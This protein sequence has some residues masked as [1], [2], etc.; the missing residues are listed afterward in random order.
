MMEENKDKESRKENL[1]S[2]I[3][4]LHEGQDI[5]ELKLRFKEIIGGVS[6]SEIGEIEQELI[7]EGILS[8]EE[9]TELCDL[10]VEIFKESLDEKQKPESIPGHPIHT[11]MLENTKAI[12]LIHEIRNTP[13][14]DQLKRIEELSKIDV[15]YTRMENQLFPLLENI[16]ISG[17]P[18]V[19]WAVHDDIRDRFRKVDLSMIKKLLKKVEDLIYKEENILFPMTL[20]KFTEKDWLR[21]REGEEE[22]GYAW[23]APGNEWKPI[24]TFHI[25]S[26]GDISNHSEYLNLDTGKLTLKQVNLMLKYLPVDISFVD[27]NNEVKYYSATDDRIF[28]RSPAVIGRKV[29]KC[30]PPKSVH[31]VEDILNKFKK[32][33]KNSAEFWIQLGDRMIYIRYFAVWDNQ[34]K[35]IGTLEVSQ[36]ITHIKKLEGERRLVQWSE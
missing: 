24:T 28:P 2:L 26:K 23:V 3:I 7:D 22:I 31:I 19:M 35:Y 25:H 13:T 21:V 20:E 12:E 9:I 15:H 4:G 29:Q 36:D 16:G 33:E 17:P 34:G 6:S 11:Y 14:E 30:H 5:E 8:P 10:H 18:Q 1:K 32:G 27:V